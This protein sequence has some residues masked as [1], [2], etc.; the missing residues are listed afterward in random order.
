MA[1]KKNEGPVGTLSRGL[2]LLSCVAKA[3]GHIG[4][5]KLAQTAG[6]NLGTAHRLASKLVE[7]GYL[8]RDEKNEFSLGLNVL[9]LGFS[10]LASL[11]IRT[12]AMPELQ[13]LR[14]DLDC[15]VSLCVLD[16]TDIV[17]VER[18]ESSSLQP[19]I[20]AV[21]GSR[22][23]VHSTAI[24]KAILA[25]LP[26]AQQHAIVERMKF[27]GYTRQ[28]V[29]SRSDFE[30]DLQ[31]TKRRG[32]ALSDQEHFE[33]YRAVAAPIFDKSGHVI[34]AIVAGAVLGRFSNLRDLREVVAPRVIQAG[35]GIS[36]RLG[37]AA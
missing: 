11:D 8:E 15:A 16:G 19:S 21:V 4:L 28:T 3:G 2:H 5:T 14:T 33:G 12:Q 27:E 35:H 9:D 26:P 20:R 24:G 22:L 37:W 10:Y 1:A 30:A 17:Y 23:P 7:L 25:F 18:L 36:R 31:T 32:Y 29:R 13:R 6:L 34:A